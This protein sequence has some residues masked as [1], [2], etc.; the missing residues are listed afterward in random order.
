LVAGT[1]VQNLNNTGISGPLTVTTTIAAVGGT[2]DLYTVHVVSSWNGGT[3]AVT[4][5]SIVR[6]GD[7]N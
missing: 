4:L 3:K 6:Y 1:T 7:V 5:D 2:P